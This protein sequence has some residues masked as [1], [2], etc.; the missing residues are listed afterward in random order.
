MR[1]FF[2]FVVVRSLPYGFHLKRESWFMNSA[3]EIKSWHIIV[4]IFIELFFSFIL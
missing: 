2:T 1:I 4:N 3:L